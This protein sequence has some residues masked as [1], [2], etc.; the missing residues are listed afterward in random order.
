MTSPTLPTS[1]RSELSELSEL[2]DPEMDQI[3]LSLGR[4]ALSDEIS[5]LD[6]SRIV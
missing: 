3:T 4:Q 1:P 5:P 6:T 2:P